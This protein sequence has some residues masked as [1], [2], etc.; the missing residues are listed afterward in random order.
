MIRNYRKLMTSAG[1][2][3]AAESG[4]PFHISA[5]LPFDWVFSNNNSKLLLVLSLYFLEPFYCLCLE[6]AS[7][8]MLHKLIFPSLLIFQ[9]LGACGSV[10][11]CSQFISIIIYLPGSSEL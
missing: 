9:D 1:G 11:G 3:K 10:T 5:S 2:T 6:N 7:M 4:K 8:V